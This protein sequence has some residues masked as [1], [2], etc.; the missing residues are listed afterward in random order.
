MLRKGIKENLDSWKYISWSWIGAH[1][2][3]NINFLYYNLKFKLYDLIKITIAF[4]NW[5]S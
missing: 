2:N 5:A 1:S 4:F 3:K